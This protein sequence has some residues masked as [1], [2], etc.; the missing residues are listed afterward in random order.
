MFLLTTNEFISDQYSHILKTD[1]LPAKQT[2]LYAFSNFEKRIQEL[3]AGK[4]MA[5]RVKSHFDKFT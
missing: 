1:D 2:M 4:Q 3:E 5:K